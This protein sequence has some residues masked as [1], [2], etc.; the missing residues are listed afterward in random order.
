MDP[1]SNLIPPKK[2]LFW[3]MITTLLISGTGFLALLYY[4]HV[5]E[6]Y[7]SDETYR[8]AAIVQA[9]PD[10]EALK[11]AYFSELLDLSIDRP[12]NLYR[13]NS[14]EA[15]RKLLASPLIKEA[16]VKKVRPGMI[17]IDYVLRK[18]K[19]FLIDYT[20]TA[21]DA[22]WVALPFNPFFT[23]KR[24]PEV[25]LGIAKP[26]EGSLLSGGAWGKPL[27]GERVELAKSLFALLEKYAT[28]SLHI[29][30]IDVSCAFAPSCGQRQIVVM[31]EQ[32]IMNRAVLLRIPLI[33][34]LSTDHY[35]Q[36]IENYFVLHAELIK[37]AR[38]GIKEGEGVVKL[39]PTI[40]DLRLPSLA[41]LKKS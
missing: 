20:N 31:I 2:A 4:R 5:K 39:A 36:G 25:Y 19:A 3:L 14:K 18:P 1:N 41:F 11:T 13:F 9:T 22:D 21:I 38:E 10:K 35:V 23:P 17:F 37:K 12:S 29:E 8:I 28:D 27:Q 26:D 34:R 33:L 40:V 6:L 7:A 15:R 16:Q 32:Q 24:L 30:R